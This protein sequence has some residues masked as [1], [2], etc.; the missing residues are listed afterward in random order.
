MNRIIHVILLTLVINPISGLAQERPGPPR[1][2]GSPRGEGERARMR[3]GEG[4][5]GPRDVE[6]PRGVPFLE[7]LERM[8]N[9]L[10]TV[11]RYARM[12]NSPAS[13]GIAAVITANDILRPRGP[14]AAIDYFNKLLPQ[15]KNEAV[16]R[17]IRIHLIELYR[18]SGQADKA[19]EHI[20]QLVT[21]VAAGEPALN[22]NPQ[23]G[24]GDR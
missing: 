21:S 7:Q 5:R 19:L 6:G 12:A 9:Y 4:F 2:P 16:Q 18:Q 8:R 17:V 1:E 22:P 14:E 20:Q 10:D 13:A 24:R 11:D 15:V 3:E 23:P